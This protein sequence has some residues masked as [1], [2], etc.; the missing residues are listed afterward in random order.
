MNFQGRGRKQQQP[1]LVYC[2]R[3]K[4]VH[5]DNPQTKQDGQCTHNV[6]LRRIREAI[7]AV[8]GGGW[9]GG[10]TSVGVCLRACSLTNPA[11]NTPPYCHLRPLWPHCIFWHYLITDTIIGRK[12][13]NIKREFWF[14]LNLLFET[15]LVVR[16][17]HRDVINVKTS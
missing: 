2:G 11:C 13:L 10:C 7:V 17:I 12:V 8:R 14:S 5:H 1:T 15:F 9:M 4:W 6:T 3:R 16:R